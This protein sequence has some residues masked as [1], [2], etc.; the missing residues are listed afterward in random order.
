VGNVERDVSERAG[1]PRDTECG[2]AAGTT[3]ESKWQ[4]FTSMSFVNAAIIPRPTL[5]NVLAAEDSALGSTPNLEDDSASTNVSINDND[6]DE[7]SE[8]G[9]DESQVK[10][11]LETR[12]KINFQEEGLH[13]QKRKIKLMEERLIKKSKADED[14]GYMFL[15]SLLPSLKKLDDIQG[16]ELGIE[17]LSNVTRRIRISKNIL[18]PFNS[19]P[20]ASHMVPSAPSPHAASLDATNSLDSDSSTHTSQMSVISSADLLQRQ[21]QVQ[22]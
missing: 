3:R 8:G 14:E 20:L 19:V 1:K 16:R 15:M 4:Y 13:L 10:K 2:Q 11:N 21:F 7:F 6:N 5:S 18:P 22:F 9:S 17:F 12:R